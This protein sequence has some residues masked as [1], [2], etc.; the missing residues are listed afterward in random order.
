MRIVRF[1]G[2]TALWLLRHKALV[3]AAVVAVLFISPLV[4]T[5]NP[6]IFLLNGVGLVFVLFQ[7]RQLVCAW[8]I[9]RAMAA[10]ER[11]QRQRAGS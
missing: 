10:R 1:V 4:V 11:A 9:G 7:L 6:E 2:R 8:A 3:A 5:R